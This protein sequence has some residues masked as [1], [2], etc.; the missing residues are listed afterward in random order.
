MTA[1]KMRMRTTTAI[2]INFILLRN[3][4]EK[5]GAICLGSASVGLDG[6][7]VL[8]AKY[9][10]F[11]LLSNATYAALLFGQKGQQVSIRCDSVSCHK[12]GLEYIYFVSDGSP[13]HRQ[14]Q[15]YNGLP[16]GPCLQTVWKR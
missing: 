14:R 8:S 16:P 2:M 15:T 7:E 9:H 11:F 3:S 4:T 5:P 10:F 6:C 13:S 1:S 12:V